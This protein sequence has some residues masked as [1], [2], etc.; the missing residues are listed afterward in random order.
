MASKKFGRACP[1]PLTFFLTGFCFLLLIGNMF[2]SCKSG[3]PKQNINWLDDPGWDSVLLKPT[4]PTDAK[5]IGFEKKLIRCYVRGWL[6][7]F[8]IDSGKHYKIKGK[9]DFI[10][11]S[12][13]PLQFRVT[14][15]LH[16]SARPAK[17]HDDHDQDDH[18]NPGG[19]THLYPP[20]PPPPKK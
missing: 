1:G 17:G 7:E 18:R 19:G 5:E 4:D 8:N 12:L 14:A 10:Q 16:P 6:E 9:I 13:N 15:Y 11:D 3:Q 2:M 20:E